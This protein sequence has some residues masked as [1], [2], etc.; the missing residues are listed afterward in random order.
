MRAEM[1]RRSLHGFDGLFSAALLACVLGCGDD[2]TQRAR[3]LSADPVYAHRGDFLTIPECPKGTTGYVNADGPTREACRTAIEQRGYTH[4]YVSITSDKKDFFSDAS[5]FE[6][7]LKELV[8]AGIEPVVF[9]TSDTGPWKDK[10]LDAIE[11]DLSAFIPKIDGLVNSYVLGIEIDEYWSAREADEIGKHLHALTTKKVAAHQLPGKWSYCKGYDWC[12]Y[13]VLQYGFGKTPEQIAETTRDA[14][15]ALGKPVIAG[16]YNISGDES[17]SRSLG[18]AAVSAGAAGFGNGAGQMTAPSS[19]PQ[20]ALDWVSTGRAYELGHA[21]VGNVQPYVDRSFTITALSPALDGLPMLR[22]ANDDKNV[23]AAS[24][25]EFTLARPSTVYVAYSGA[26]TVLPAWLSDGT[27]TQSAETLDM[28]DTASNPRRLYQ[29]S[30]A[31]GQVTL[32]GN[33]TSPAAGPGGFSNYV[34]V[35]K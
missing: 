26:A 8:D 1:L 22:T 33:R 3:A 10:S 15:A 35:I 9:L 11:A 16:E 23:D 7:R 28:S 20:I 32:G 17:T 18:N 29:K 2:A 13:M 24:H 34:V 27:W 14:M 12:S 4:H 6:A 5:T 21:E 30:F 25:L 31:A 19:P